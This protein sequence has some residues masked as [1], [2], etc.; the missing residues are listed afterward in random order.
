MEFCNG[1]VSFFH[2]RRH[3]T[4]AAFRSTPGTI[5]LKIAPVVSDK[6]QARHPLICFFVISKS[7]TFAESVLR[8]SCLVSSTYVSQD[9]WVSSSLGSLNCGR[10]GPWIRSSAWC[11]NSSAKPT[12]SLDSDNSSHH[13]SEV[14]AYVRIELRDCSRLPQDGSSPSLM[15]DSWWASRKPFSLRADKRPGSPQDL[16]M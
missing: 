9:A 14:S 7:S 5:I 10:H 8:P 12:N 3:A 4:T 16:S 11:L 2:T 1:I 6:P 15:K 13:N